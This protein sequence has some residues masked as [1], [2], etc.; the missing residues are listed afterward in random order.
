VPG[1]SLLQHGD[2]LATLD[3][4]NTFE[5]GYNSL[6]L[7]WLRESVL[8]LFDRFEHLIVL[9]GEILHLEFTL[10]VT[11]FHNFSVSHEIEFK[12][13]LVVDLEV[14]LHLKLERAWLLQGG[15]LVGGAWLLQGGR[16]VG[17]VLGN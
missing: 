9:L 3:Y 2:A 14:L 15:R 5:F 4:I 1:L 10:F 8:G 13:L 6:L 17:G 12:V 11:I 16:L 7:D